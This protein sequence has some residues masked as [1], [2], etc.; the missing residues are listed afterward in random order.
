M[1]DSAKIICSLIGKNTVD[2]PIVECLDDQ[3][4][5]KK[6]DLGSCRNKKAIVGCYNNCRGKHPHCLNNLEAPYWR[7]LIPI[8]LK[9]CIKR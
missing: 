8:G 3:C 1:P 7:L 5:H 4:K 9:Q 2:D 6:I